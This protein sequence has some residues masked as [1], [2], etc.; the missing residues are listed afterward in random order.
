[1]TEK[2]KIAVAGAAH[3]HWPD[4]E[5]VLLE[6]CDDVEV[7]AVYDRDPVRAQR[8][9]ETFGAHACREFPDFVSK[10]EDTPNV[11]IAPRSKDHGGLVPALAV[12]GK[13]VFI[14]KPISLD[15]EHARHC[16]SLLSRP[17]HDGT[18]RLVHVNL[19][20]RDHK[21]FQRLKEIVEGGELGEIISA[22][23]TCSH[24]GL[25]LGWFDG[26]YAWMKKKPALGGFGDLGLHSVDLLT[27]M[28]GKPLSL[29][30][31]TGTVEGINTSVQDH[32]GTGKMTFKNGVEGS[33]YAGW[34]APDDH[35]VSLRV[36]GTRGD[37]IA[38]ERQ[39]ITTIDGFLH[40]QDYYNTELDSG[41]G[42]RRFLDALK[43]PTVELV[44]AQQAADSL[45]IMLRLYREAEK[46]K[47]PSRRPVAGGPGGR[48]LSGPAL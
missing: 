44:S 2:I 30:A 26:E 37:A 20:H 23:H 11:I 38:T 40:T 32:F 45:D 22:E 21:P 5:R 19:F 42:L 28:F 27:W 31:S 41:S 39:L 35:L 34:K 29:D 12:L 33:F 9:A 7:T 48:D 13:N 10:I 17:R 16:A 43:D 25:E 24:D 1:M 36:E 14:E 4:F 46:H 6:R 8:I 3:I 15:A 18:E 47:Q